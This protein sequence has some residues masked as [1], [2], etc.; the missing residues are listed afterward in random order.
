[1]SWLATFVGWIT[2]ALLT[3]AKGL[4][5][6]ALALAKQRADTTDA[7][8]KSVEP[9]KGATD[10]KDIDKASDDALNGF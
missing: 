1:M 2:S 10:A 4:V 5:Q 9:L 6:S 3:W 8:K 7:A